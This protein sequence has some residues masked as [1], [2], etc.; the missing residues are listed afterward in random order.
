MKVILKLTSISERKKFGL[1]SIDSIL[2]SWLASVDTDLKSHKAANLLTSS[3][4]S[5]FSRKKLYHVLRLLG[6]FDVSTHVVC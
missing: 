5:S 3:A 6:L 2:S 4:A 1:E